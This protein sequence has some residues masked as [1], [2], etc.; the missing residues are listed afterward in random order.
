PADT[1]PLS[2]HDAL[3][4]YYAHTPDAL[5]QALRSLRDHCAGDLTCVFGCGGERD[6][7]KRPFMAAIAERL[8][9]CVIVT[10]DNPRHEDG[11]AIVDRKSTRLNSS[12]VSIS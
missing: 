11:D 10:D 12:H 9:D 8:A 7:G 3:P 4:I 6:A 1:C 2:L 5:E